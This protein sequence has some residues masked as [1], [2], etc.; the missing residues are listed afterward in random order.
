MYTRKK[1]PKTQYELSTGRE[2]KT[3]Q[4]ENDVRRDNDK[5]KPFTTGLFD[6]DFAVKYYF[7]NVIRPE[8]DDLGSKI[9]VPVMYGSPEKWKNVQADGYIRDKNGKI[10]VPL[11][12][13]KRNTVEKDRTLSNKVDPNYPHIYYNQE[14]KY[15]KEN[16]YD[17]FSKLTN[18]KPIKTYINTVVPDFV[19]VSYDVLIWTDYIEHMNSIVETVLYTEGAYWGEKERFKFRAKIDSFTNTTD[20]LQDSDRVIRTN[21]TLN[22][23]G[24]IFT[25]NLAKEFSYKQSEKT[26]DIRQVVLDTEV[27]PDPTIFK[28]TDRMETKFPSPTVQSSQ[29]PIAPNPV[30]VGI[31]QDVLNYLAASLAI[32]AVSITSNTAIFSGYRFYPRPNALPPIS[33]DGF[34][35]FINGQYVEPSAVISFLDYGSGVCTLILDTVALGFELASTDEVVAVG[36]FLSV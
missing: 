32:P 31:N 22:L 35:F 24:Q 11:I 18:S 33:Q 16:I 6:L 19:N 2:Q 8:I 13:Y 28:T 23:Y 25:E 10:Q 7:E 30:L 34:S 4:R 26:F 17:Q 27:D 5:L 14:V 1:L 29:S 9:K 12:A 36:K 21:F 20:L 3:Y 15:T